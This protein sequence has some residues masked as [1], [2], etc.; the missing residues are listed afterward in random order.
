MLLKERINEAAV[1]DLGRK[2]QS[3]IINIVALGLEIRG[4]NRRV[5]HSNCAPHSN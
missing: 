2:A 3:S 1:M 5:K 4:L